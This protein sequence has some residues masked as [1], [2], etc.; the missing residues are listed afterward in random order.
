MSAAPVAY[1][2]SSTSG[3]PI[4]VQR[5][6]EGGGGGGSSCSP[7][8]ECAVL[9]LT[10]GDVSYPFQYLPITR[11]ANPLVF[12]ISGNLEAFGGVYGQSDNLSPGGHFPTARIQMNVANGIA[13]VEITLQGLNE[14]T[15]FASGTG[16]ATVE[17]GPCSPGP[18][19]FVETHVTLELRYLGKTN[20]FERHVW[21]CG[22]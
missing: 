17:V 19:V 7:G 12:T 2:L 5:V 3:T 6:D 1:S 16:S 20:I 9:T 18:A 4:A 10:A 13:S 8:V 11:T 22:A 21:P 14:Q 15:F